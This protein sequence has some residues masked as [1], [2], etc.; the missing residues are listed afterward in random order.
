MLNL[1]WTSSQGP[2][3]N[4][5]GHLYVEGSPVTIGLKRVGKIKINIYKVNI[6]NDIQIDV[7]RYF[8][9]C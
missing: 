8:N 3:I 1:G 5:K 9:K 4:E 2:K 6:Q 7:N